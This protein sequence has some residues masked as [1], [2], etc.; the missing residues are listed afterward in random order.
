MF[1]ATRAKSP[2][3]LLDI[4]TFLFAYDKLIIKHK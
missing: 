1:Q 2:F 4:I 3:L